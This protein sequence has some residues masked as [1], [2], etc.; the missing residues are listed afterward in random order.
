VSTPTAFPA[1]DTK[2]KPPSEGQW[3]HEI[4]D[5]RAEKGGRKVIEVDVH[6]Q[7]WE[8][9]RIDRPVMSTSKTITSL[10]RVVGPHIPSANLACGRNSNNKRAKMLAELERC[11]V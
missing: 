9:E 5:R 7:A 3:G 11:F 6:G 4:V 2:P 10:Y 1:G 8:L